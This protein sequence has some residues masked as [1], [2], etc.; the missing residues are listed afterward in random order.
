MFARV[1]G[2]RNVGERVAV[3]AGVVVAELVQLG[4]QTGAHGGQR[5]QCTAPDGHHGQVENVADFVERGQ[6][7]VH[8]IEL[9]QHLF[10]RRNDEEDDDFGGDELPDVNL[11]VDEQP[12]ADDEQRGGNQNFKRHKPPV[13]QQEHPKVALPGAQVAF[14]QRVGAGQGQLLPGRVAK[15]LHGAG[16]VFEPGHH[17]VLVLRFEDA[18]V[19]PAG[20]GHANHEGQQQHQQHPESNEDGVVEG[21]QNQ[22]K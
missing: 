4:A 14:H 22:P 21:E 10:H 5:Q 6:R 3:R 12:A 19:Q 18:G 2:E 16:H 8:Y 13:L 7:V 9:K 1:N 17:A 15:G 11:T 20:A